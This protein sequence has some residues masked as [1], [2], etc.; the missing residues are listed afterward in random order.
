M[1]APGRPT[2]DATGGF[3]YGGWM[4]PYFDEEGGERI[5]ALFSGPFDLLL[6][7]RT[8]DIFADYWPYAEGDSIGRKFG[9]AAKYVLARG[10]QPLGWENSHRVASLDALAELKMGDG[11]DLIVQGSSALYPNC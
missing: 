9:R 7:Q 2:E 11:P 1:Q 8:H 6:G 5:D 10:D 3:E 4:A